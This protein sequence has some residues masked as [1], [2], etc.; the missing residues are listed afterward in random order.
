M[1]PVNLLEIGGVLGVAVVKLIDDGLI[2]F[3]LAEVD[4]PVRDDVDQDQDCPV[5]KSSAS[6][7]SW[8]GG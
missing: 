7:S 2:S 6:E 4:V 3:S 5:Q 8:P 1:L